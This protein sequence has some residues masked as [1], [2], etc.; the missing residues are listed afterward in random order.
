MHTRI[1]LLLDKTVGSFLNVLLYGLVRLLGKILRINHKL[2]RPFERIVVCKFKGMGS[3][4]QA[5]ALLATLRKSYPQADIRFVS[6]QTNAGIL[7]F[8]SDTLTGTFLVDDSR[9]VKVLGSTMRVLYH[10]W[11]FKPQVY[12]DLEIYSNYS[13]LLCTLSAATNRLGYY[14]S[15][16]DYRTGLFTHLMYYNIKAPLSEIYLQM[17]RILPVGQVEHGLIL[18]AISPELNARAR[19]K[20]RQIQPLMHDSYLV[21]N[22]NA[23]DLRLE[24]RWPA[25]NF[26]QLIATLREKHPNLTIVLVGNQQESIYVKGIATHFS[27]DEHVIDSSG[28]L[29]LDELMAVLDGATGVITNDTGPLHMSLALRKPTVGL[30][31][32]CSPSQYGQMES[33]IPIYTNVY[34]SPCVHEFLTPPCA[35]DN[36]CMKQMT[37]VSVLNAVEQMLKVSPVSTDAVAIGYESPAQVLGFI[38]NR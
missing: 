11:K 12:I 37:V 36:Q 17:A 20:L 6:T 23:S 26:I 14:K 19:A 29:K 16:K 22:P 15:D 2:D 33:C 5:S 25:A 9:F 31:G 28:L 32:P 7:A 27:G 8:Y 34:C 30:F 38:N 10:L 21:L 24:R 1:Q 13:S 18:P 3:I 35:G 4:V